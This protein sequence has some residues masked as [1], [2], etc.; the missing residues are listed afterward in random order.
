[1]LVRWL[2]VNRRVVDTVLAADKLVLEPFR[3]HTAV[4]VVE[5]I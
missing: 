3:Q 2:T 5:K 4:A 1:V